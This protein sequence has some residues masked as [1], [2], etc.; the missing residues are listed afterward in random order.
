MQTLVIEHLTMRVRAY[1]HART[2]A[3]MHAHTHTHTI[4]LYVSLILLSQDPTIQNCSLIH[5]LPIT[6]RLPY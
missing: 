1:M 2:H 6:L 3:R 5:P 4:H